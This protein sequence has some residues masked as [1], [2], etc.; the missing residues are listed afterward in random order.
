MDSAVWP[1]LTGILVVV[2]IGLATLLIIEREKKKS[3]NQNRGAAFSSRLSGMPFILKRTVSPDM[4]EEA[5]ERLRVLDLEREIL[6]YAIRRLYEAHAEGKITEEE[7]DRLAEKYR[8][9]LAR[10]KEEIAR[11]E[12]IVALNELERM[13]EEFIKLFSDRFDEL[14]RRIEQL[15]MISGLAPSEEEELA[16]VEEEVKV[17]EEKEPKEEKPIKKPVA[18]KP[19]KRRIQ[20][21]PPSRPEKSDAEKRVEQIVAEVEKVLKKLGQMEVEE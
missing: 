19:K 14:T 9:E 21:A 3:L 8:L 20:T 13:Q 17:E 2:S 11:G 15:R 10:I 5:K 18:S 12:S 1:W 6:G 7:R 16:E 4:Y